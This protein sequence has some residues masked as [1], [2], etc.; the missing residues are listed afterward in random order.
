M[1]SIQPV[2][3]YQPGIASLNPPTAQA[4]SFDVTIINDNLVDMC[5]MYFELYDDSGGRVYYGNT[6]IVGDDY[7][8]WNGNNDYPYQYIAKLFSLTILE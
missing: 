3:V 8:N 7:A 4:T 2:S 1:K 5:Q 6:S